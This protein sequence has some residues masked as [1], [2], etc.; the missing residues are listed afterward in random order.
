MPIDVTELDSLLGDKSVRGRKRR[1]TP[2]VAEARRK[3]STRRASRA[4]SLARTALVRLYPA[5][6]DRL[7]KQALARIN[8]ES[9]PLP[10]EEQS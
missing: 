8:E 6:Y 7:H 2:E 10:G 1:F 3:E 4:A 9:G 5:D